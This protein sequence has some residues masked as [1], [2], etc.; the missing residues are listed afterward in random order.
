[1]FMAL[2]S[3]CNG[4]MNV[5]LGEGGL[6]LKTSTLGEKGHIFHSLSWKK[7]HFEKKDGG[8]LH[9]VTQPPSLLIS[10]P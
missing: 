4:S 7:R 9:C 5:N 2:I 3:D 8:T 10:M 1:M 6:H